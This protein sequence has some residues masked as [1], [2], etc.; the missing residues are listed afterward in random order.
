MTLKRE[1]ILAAV[2]GE[3]ISWFLIFIIK[4]PQVQ[5][6]RSL[7]QLSFIIWLLPLALPLLSAAGIVIAHIFSKLFKLALQLA[8]FAVVG[9]LNTAMDFGLLNLMIWFSAITS[10]LYLAIFNALS[11]SA[12]V[13]NSFFWNKYWTF[14]KEGGAK[15]REFGA[16]V[17]V[18][19]IGIGINTFIVFLGTSFFE[20][21]FGL[22]GGA[23]AN[24]VKI[25]ATV[26]SMV[27]NFAGYKFVVFK[28]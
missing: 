17:L 5:E 19:L 12:T 11:F 6:L 22:S 14:E 3:L 15:G 2:A 7:A 13:I 10:G 24:L 28:K 21:P 23:W 18:S 27:W 4:N 20:A 16:F 8:R 25:L 9:F 1:L 26:V